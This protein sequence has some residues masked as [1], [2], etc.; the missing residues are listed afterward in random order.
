MSGKKQC[1][2]VY[3]LF[4][5][6]AVLLLKALA[7]ADQVALLREDGGRR[8]HFVRGAALAAAAA[9]RPHFLLITADAV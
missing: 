3:L 2:I 4:E 8:G 1:N 7:F 5:R 9:H 6:Q